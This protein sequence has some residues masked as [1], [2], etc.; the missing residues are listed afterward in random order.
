MY[1]VLLSLRI[2]K[3]AD[4][5]G[6]T[7]ERNLPAN[8]REMGFDL[9]SGN[10]PHVSDQLNSCATIT[11]AHALRACTLPQEEPR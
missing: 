10:T 1:K 9:W 5:P 4:F 7:M 6:G 8:A 2:Q 3:R 11:E